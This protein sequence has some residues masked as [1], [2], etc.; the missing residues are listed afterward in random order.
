MEEKGEEMNTHKI[1]VPIDFSEINKELVTIADE[2]AQRTHAQ[3]YFLHV[4]PDFT[5][6]F[7]DPDVQ[8]VFGTNNDIIIAEI[9][10]RIESFVKEQGV[11]SP[12]ECLVREGKANTE[13]VEVQKELNIDQIII[14]AHD[15][16]AVGRLFVGSNTDFVL[17]HVHCP[18]YVYKNHAA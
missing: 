7:I 1:L 14:A 4:V 8:N 5:Y 13:I 16:T 9:Q 11:K 6:R 18:V 3:L 2:W 10:E 15:H 12:H 17:H